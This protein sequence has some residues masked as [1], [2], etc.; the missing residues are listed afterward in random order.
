M[1]G[2]RF[3]RSDD[4]PLLV[5]AH[6]ACWVPHF[7][8]ASALTV[9]DFKRGIREIGL[10]SS[11][12]MVAFEGDEPI[13]ILIAAKRDRDANY[14]H[15]LAVRPGF[16]RQGHGRHLLTSLVDKAAILGPPRVV[17]EIPADWSAVNAF[18][19]KSG[20]AEE[21]RYGDFVREAGASPGMG[22]DDPR[23]GLVVSL[24]LDELLDSGAL[25]ASSGRA[26]GRAKASLRARGETLAVWA[27]ATDRIEAHLATAPS[28]DGQGMDVLAIGAE[29][30]PQGAALLGLLLAHAAGKGSA[31][32]IPAIADDETCFDTLWALGFRRERDVIGYVARRAAAA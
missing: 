2:Y 16:E 25:D 9:D 26:W 27:V 7:G 1:A 31:L 18:F 30:G 4:I 5:A 8:P 22:A 13:G 24:S 32:R 17:A 12:C 10:W 14:V 21:R 23:A 3:C 11:S 29:A 6:N 19:V 28:R 20:F 15:R